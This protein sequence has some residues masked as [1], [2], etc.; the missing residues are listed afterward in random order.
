V[1]ICPCVFSLNHDL[2]IECIAERYAI[3][4]HAGFAARTALPRRSEDGEKIGDLLVE[5]MTEEEIGSTALRYQQPGTHGIHLL[6]IHRGLNIFA[7][8]DGADRVRVL[9]TGSGT[10]GIVDSLRAVN[11]DPLYIRPGWPKPAKVQNEIAF[12]DDQGEMQFLRRAARGGV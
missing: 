4:V 1:R 7:F 8:R 11:N 6:E 2:M 10:A 12:E 3:P 5:T 9:P